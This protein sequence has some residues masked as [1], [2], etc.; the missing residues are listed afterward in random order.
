M[1]V[2]D[3]GNESVTWCWR[4]D[5]WVLDGSMSMTF[6]ERLEL[7]ETAMSLPQAT[8]HDFLETPP[9]GDP[10]QYLRIIRDPAL[11]A[12]MMA[13]GMA[14]PI[15]VPRGRSKMPPIMR[16]YP[17]CDAPSQPTERRPTVEDVRDLL[18]RIEVEEQRLERDLATVRIGEVDRLKRSLAELSDPDELQAVLAKISHLR[19][20]GGVDRADVRRAAFKAIAEDLTF[21]QRHCLSLVAGFAMQPSSHATPSPVAPLPTP[22]REKP[23]R[24]AFRSQPAP[25]SS[26]DQAARVAQRAA[27]RAMWRERLMPL[28]SEEW[29]SVGHIA[30]TLGVPIRQAKEH[31]GILAESGL[32]VKRAV[33]IPQSPSNAQARRGRVR[34]RNIAFKEAQFRLPGRDRLKW[35]SAAGSATS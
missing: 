19:Q 4:S 31:L 24:A 22:L 2:P 16:L 23:Q 13:V 33:R 30:Q 11:R 28:L 17:N 12:R 10:P 34:R 20:L 27:Y 5:S 15:Q 6:E 32:V 26:G 21:P 18:A 1:Y 25:T 8:V 35:L 14:A 3:A 9:I 7:W 29:Q